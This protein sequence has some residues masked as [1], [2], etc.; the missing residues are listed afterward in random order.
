MTNKILI[1]ACAL[2][3]LVGCKDK[4]D[5]PNGLIG[6]IEN[7]AWEAITDYDLTSS[8]TAVVQVDLSL[9]FSEEQLQ[10]VKYQPS[11]DDMLAV[12]ANNECLGVGKE[13]DG[14]WFI[15]IVS[16]SSSPF[17]MSLQYYSA[18]LKNIFIANELVPYKNDTKLGSIE[19]PYRPIFLP[20]EK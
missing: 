3:C 2:L 11:S 9:S 8:M 1:I 4:K 14:L 12:F 13:I 16:N 19:T 18:S 10:S 5:D 7:P 17:D 20:K 6:Q 15:Y